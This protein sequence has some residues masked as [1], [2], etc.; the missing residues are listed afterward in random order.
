MIAVINGTQVHM[1]DKQAQTVFN[2]ESSK[3]GFA[4]IHGYVSTSNRITPEVANYVFNSKF[5]TIRL[6]ERKLEALRAIEFKDVD[7]TGWIA[8]K[9]RDSKPNAEMQF[10]WCKALMIQSLNATILGVRND[11]HREGH[12]ACY[13]PVCHGVKVHLV[14]AKND[15]G[16]MRPVLTDGIPTCAKVIINAIVVSKNVITPGQY[17]DVKNGSKVLMDKAIEKLMNKRSV[18]II[19]F[20]LDDDKYDT[21]KIGGLEIASES[22]IEEVTDLLIEA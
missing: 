3:H 7:V 11:P 12:D 20:S 22:E 14:T 13:I 8:S 19:T 1:T 16:L 4:S 10:E 21:L 9:G 2:L 17:K 18:K 6:Y 5:S 15:E